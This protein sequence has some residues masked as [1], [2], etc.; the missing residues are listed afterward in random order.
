[1]RS[2]RRPWRL[3]PVVA[4]HD[5]A[6]VV[7]TMLIDPRCAVHATTGILPVKTLAVPGDVTTRG[8]A[9]LDYTFLTGPLI[10][11]PDEVS[12]P[13]AG[14]GGAL[15][16]DRPRPLDE[17]PPPDGPLAPLDPT[18]IPLVPRQ[19]IVD[20]W[21]KLDRSTDPAEHDRPKAP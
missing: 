4:A 10:V 18:V 7:V 19:R 14:G 15:A 1:M 12:G 13:T 6:P 5:A 3:S 20:G 8:M 21:L 2:S 11:P 17:W 16:V 9:A